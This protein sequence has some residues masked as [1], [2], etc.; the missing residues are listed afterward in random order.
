MSSWGAAGMANKSQKYWFTK[1]ILR[2]SS[3]ANTAKG[4]LNNTS[5]ALLN[6][7]FADMV[8]HPILQ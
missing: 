4:S 1:L 5:C 8:L 3:S 7:V 6:S 2:F